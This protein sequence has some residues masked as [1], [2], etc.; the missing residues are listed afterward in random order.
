MCDHAAL[1]LSA[2]QDYFFYRKVQVVSLQQFS[3]PESNTMERSQ[4]PDVVTTTSSAVKPQK[5]EEIEK[6]KSDE[7][8]KNETS[9]MARVRNMIDEKKEWYEERKR[10]T[11]SEDATNILQNSQSSSRDDDS[12]MNGIHEEEVP[13]GSGEEDSDHSSG[14]DRSSKDSNV[15]IIP[16]LYILYLFHSLISPANGKN[17]RESFIC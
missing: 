5:V 9:F 8:P 2:I 11:A 7:L 14:D 4:E 6:V 10:K 13:G 17:V 1:R 12:K 16:K 3:L 15:S